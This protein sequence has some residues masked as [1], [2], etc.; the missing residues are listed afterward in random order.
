MYPFFPGS[1]LRL[2]SSHPLGGNEE[3]DRMLA[4]DAEKKEESHL[5]GRIDSGF[6]RRPGGKI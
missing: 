4:F 1:S 6:N 5:P 3:R 2:I